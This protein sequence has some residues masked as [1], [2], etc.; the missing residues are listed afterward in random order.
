MNAM[1]SDMNDTTQ[2]IRN[3]SSI[4]K[5]IISFMENFVL[6]EST[7][8]ELMQCYEKN[9]QYIL[10][11]LDTINT[12][13][14]FTP[15]SCTI[16]Q[17]L[18]VEKCNTQK[19]I[20][21]QQAILDSPKHRDFY[22]LLNRKLYCM[23]TACENLTSGMIAS[24]EN[25]NSFR[26]YMKQILLQDNWIDILKTVKIGLFIASSINW[27]KKNI[28]IVP[29]IDTIGSIL[30]I[31]AA[32][33][34]ERDQ[35][36]GIAQ[37]VDFAVL[38][39][40]Q[41]N[42]SGVMNLRQVV[43]KCSRLIV[44]A[45]HGRLPSCEYP[46]EENDKLGRI[47][48]FILFILAESDNTVSKE[49]ACKA[50]DC[51]FAHIMQP[52]EES[53]LYDVL[54][55]NKVDV[56]ATLEE[57]LAAAILNISV[58]TLRNLDPFTSV[59]SSSLSS[60]AAVAT[61]SSARLSTS[62]T[63]DSVTSY[64][65]WNSSTTQE[66]IV[67]N[68]NVVQDVHESALSEIEMACDAISIEQNKKEIDQLK[69][70]MDQIQKE[71]RKNKPNSNPNYDAGGG[72]VYMNPNEQTDSEKELA[73][74]AVDKELATTDRRVCQLELLLVSVVERLSS[75]EQKTEA[76]MITMKKKRN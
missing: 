28:A 30:Q 72:L 61:T 44:R 8:D 41:N 2:I 43:E 29:F 71:V 54:V 66:C 3:I 68:F 7:I 60:A 49:Q 26:S 37:V 24:N 75:L 39:C 52:K 51:A 33:K 15:E 17:Q 25:G 74:N 55:L 23:I 70:T 21:E 36:I 57:A 27:G 64:T 19:D 35:C 59:S 1:Q 56:G 67:D 10:N 22:I 16:L 34:D 46:V 48:Q 50:A 62:V 38:A 11:A 42:N 5:R 13:N 63:G 47:K 31:I 45:R 69:E 14:Q 18:I 40:L 65:I 53:I 12:T 32:S 4:D 76:M 6:N 9:N 58:D 20:I 73:A